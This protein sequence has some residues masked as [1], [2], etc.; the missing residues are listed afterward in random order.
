MSTSVVGLR[1]DDLFELRKEIIDKY[2]IFRIFKT[3]QNY[4]LQVTINI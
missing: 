2:I 1:V 3:Y 4:L